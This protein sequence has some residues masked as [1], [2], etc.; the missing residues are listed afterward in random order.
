VLAFLEMRLRNEAAARE[1][2]APARRKKA[3]AS[4]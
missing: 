3:R 2:P 4:A 1:K